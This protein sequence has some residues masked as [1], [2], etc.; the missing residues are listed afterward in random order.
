[1]KPVN[2]RKVAAYDPGGTTGAAYLQNTRI[3][4]RSQIG[5]MNTNSHI[6]LEKDL[7]AFWPDVVVYEQ[8]DY[9]QNQDTAELI[10]VKYIGVIEWWCLKHDVPWVAQKPAV[11]KVTGKTVFWDVRKLKHLGLWL[12]NMPHAMDATSHLLHYWSFTLRQKNYLKLLTGL[13]D[14]EDD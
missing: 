6:P 1:M 12:P 8:F 5:N 3:V 7:D 2:L 9:R 13:G 10:S 4:A 11:G 14:F